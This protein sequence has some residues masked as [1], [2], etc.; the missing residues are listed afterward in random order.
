M[1]KNAAIASSVGIQDLGSCNSGF[2]NISFNFNDLFYCILF[3]WYVY[4]NIFHNLP[5]NFSFFWSP[6]QVLYWGQCCMRWQLDS[7]THPV[8]QIDWNLLDM[9]SWLA[10]R[11]SHPK[12]QKIRGRV[13]HSSFFMSI[14]LWPMRLHLLWSGKNHSF[15]LMFL[16][17]AL[18]PVCRAVSIM[19]WA[20]GPCPCLDTIFKSHV[21]SNLH[22]SHK[23]G[24]LEVR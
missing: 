3:Q 4:S 8:H 20:F 13:F 17:H 15:N 18:P 10:T 16:Q 14:I 12:D 23:V 6:L 24:L 9:A 5:C 1:S 2:T 11:I 22:N 19:R 21:P 7:N